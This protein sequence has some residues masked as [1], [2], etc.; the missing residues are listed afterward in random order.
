[1]DPKNANEWETCVTI[2]HLNLPSGWLAKSYVGLTATTGQLA[3]N[4][5]IIYLKTSSDAELLERK[6]E[7]AKIH[8]ELEDDLSSKDKFN[9]LVEVTNKLIDAH[10]TLDH[11]VEHQLASVT[12]HIK[13]L[14][15][16]LEKRE[17][18]SETRLTNLE[19]IIKKV[20]DQFFYIDVENGSNFLM[21]CINVGSGRLFGNSF[22]CIGVANER[23]CGAQD[24]Q[25]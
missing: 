23:L 24:D 12:D 21:V 10:E 20:E 5:D 13:N 22:V 8:F 19:E 18:K 7:E 15:G 3:D 1:M 25:Y 11:H 9:R 2:P 4:H 14:I 17:D 16:K 6:E